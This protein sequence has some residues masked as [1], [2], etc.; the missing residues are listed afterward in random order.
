MRIW[1]DS[2]L[3]LS[4]LSFCVNLFFHTNLFYARHVHEDTKPISKADR[5]TN[6]T[7]TPRI[8]H[9]IRRKVESINSLSSNL[10]HGP[11]CS[12]SYIR[13]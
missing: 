4:L 3:P 9:E 10:L 13:R 12:I 11:H 7:P 6:P 1:M 2:L 5:V 8:K